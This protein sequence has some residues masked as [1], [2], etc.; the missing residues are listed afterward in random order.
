M[1]IKNVRRRTEWAG[2]QGRA[3]A[4]EHNASTTRAAAGRAGLQGPRSRRAPPRAVALAANGG[5]SRAVVCPRAA[6]DVIASSARAPPVLLPFAP[7]RTFIGL[8]ACVS[9]P[10]CEPS[11]C[12]ASRCVALRS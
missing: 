2:A 4:S 12:V 3:S 5:R 7:A 6:A 8:L 1:I 9:R 11:L 10:P